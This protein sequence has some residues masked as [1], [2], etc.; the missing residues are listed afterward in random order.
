MNTIIRAMT[1]AAMASLLFGC[2]TGAQRQYQAMTVN[3]QGA[4]QRLTACS[5]ET[6]NSPEFAPLRAHIPLSVANATLE[7]LSDRSFATGEEIRIILA[8]HPRFQECRKAALTQIAQTTPTI[9]PIMLGLINKSEESLVDLIQK[10][11]SWGDHVR[12]VKAA[13]TDSTTQFVAEI[14]HIQ[15]G[16]EQSHEAELARRQAAFDALGRWGE[17]L[18]SMSN[19]NRG[20]NCTTT[21]M[22]TV[23]STQP[24]FSTTNCY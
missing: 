17:S 20:I 1:I 14:R 18:Q 21:T 8:T 24:R 19:M 6:Y 10:K 23:V 13:T 16:L 12:R 4:V 7:Q 11:Q 9:V 15:G 5:M 2:G 22:P 3:N